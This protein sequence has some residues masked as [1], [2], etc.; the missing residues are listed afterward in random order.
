MNSGPRW[1]IICCPAAAITS[2][3]S[4]VGPG[5]R[6]FMLTSSLAD[7]RIRARYGRTRQALGPV[8]V[9]GNGDS[10]RAAPAT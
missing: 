10:H 6:R 8:Y 5:I 9:H 2:G 4:G 7:G 3:G 1:L